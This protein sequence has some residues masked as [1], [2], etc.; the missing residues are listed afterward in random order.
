[1]LNFLAITNFIVHQTKYAILFEK[2]KTGKKQ[3]KQNMYSLGFAGNMYQL[4]KKGYGDS[5][6]MENTNLFTFF[7]LLLKE[8]SD[9]VSELEKAGKKKGEIAEI[10]NLTIPQVN[11]LIS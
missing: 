8:L 7:D 11:D 3:K 1:L 4:S 10:M 9:S 5:E 2:P 6:K